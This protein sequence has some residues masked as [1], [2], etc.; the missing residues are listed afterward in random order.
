MFVANYAY[1]MLVCEKF[2]H[3]TMKSIQC[4]DVFTKTR[5]LTANNVIVMSPYL[6]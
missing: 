2:G 3:V 5:W 1:A 6:E 4:C